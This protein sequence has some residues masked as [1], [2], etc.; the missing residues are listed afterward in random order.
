M[1]SQLW[2]IY[3]KKTSAKAATQSTAHSQLTV[4]KGKMRK[5]WGDRGG[6]MA[7]KDQKS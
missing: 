4:G 7:G 1:I 6:N 2:I 5:L 3:G